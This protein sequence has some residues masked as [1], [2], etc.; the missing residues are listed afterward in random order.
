MTGRGLMTRRGWVH[1]PAYLPVTTFG[2]KYPL[3]RL[4]QPYLARLAGAVMVAYHYARQMT[5][6][7]RPALPLWVDSGGFAAL[8]KGSRVLDRNGLGTIEIAGT[9]GTDQVHPAGVLDLQ[10]QVAEVAFTLDFPIPPGLEPVEARRRQDLTMANA[11]WALANRRRRDLP[12][13]AVVQ[14]WDVESARAC[15]RAYAGQ[16][17]DGIAIGGLVPRVR[18][19]ALVL[20]WVKSVRAE[21]G[22]R[23]LHVFGLGIPELV[24]D[25]F[26][27]GVDSVDS[28]AYVKL[29]AEGRLWSKRD[30][31]CGNPT[32][33]ERLHLALCNLAAAS[34]A[35]LPLS[36]A[37]LQ[38]RTPFL[39]VPATSG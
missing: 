21:I 23:P 38:F 14:G 19:R 9:E 10:E 12:L 7:R 20:A 1:F 18:D 37:P 15:A 22:D 8:F 30:Y 36:A 26:R 24:A 28:S 33:T 29:A 27:A 13:Y 5:P 17:F 35:T 2:D 25:L 11:R 4:L 39:S 32:A 16:A 3:D 6:D 34:G 31:Q